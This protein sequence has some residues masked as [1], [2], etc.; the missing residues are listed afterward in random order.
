MIDNVEKIAL[1]FI[2]FQI[3]LK[4]ARIKNKRELAHLQ[5]LLTEEQR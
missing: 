1:D 5:F 3:Y 2:G 4:D